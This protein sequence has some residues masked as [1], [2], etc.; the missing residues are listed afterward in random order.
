MIKLAE[1]PPDGHAPDLTIT[2]MA[3]IGYL[4]S[5]L[6]IKALTLNA[7]RVQIVIMS[8]I[9]G[10]TRQLLGCYLLCSVRASRPWQNMYVTAT[11]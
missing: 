7:E 5:A 10:V 9:G 1:T 6:V 11:C 8:N 2:P 4:E 3:T